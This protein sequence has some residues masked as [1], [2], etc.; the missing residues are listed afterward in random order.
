MRPGGP[1]CLFS[2]ARKDNV[3]FSN[4]RNTH[5][6]LSI[7]RKYHVP[8]HCSRNVACH[9]K[10]PRLGSRPREG[11]GGGGAHCLLFECVCLLL[12]RVTDHRLSKS[13]LFTARFSTILQQSIQSI[14]HISLDKAK[15]NITCCYCLYYVLILELTAPKF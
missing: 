4:I 13:N 5:I 15:T 1:L 6:I 10:T 7:L 2:V 11:E 12:L 3:V 14:S 9:Y 8:S